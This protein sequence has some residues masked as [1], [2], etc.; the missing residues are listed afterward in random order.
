LLYNNINDMTTIIKKINI[1]KKQEEIIFYNC[2][3]D[4]IIDKFENDGNKT[5]IIIFYEKFQ[6]IN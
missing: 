6:R 3:L 4:K 5:E 2:Y 1:T